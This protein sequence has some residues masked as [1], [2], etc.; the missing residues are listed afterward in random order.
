MGKTNKRLSF[1]VVMMTAILWFAVAPQTVKADVN[2]KE[3]DID[4]TIRDD[5]S[6]IITQEW[7]AYTDEGTEYY[8]Y[9]KDSGYLEFYN[10][11][12][13]DS[14]K[15]YENI[16]EWDVDAEFDEKAYKCGINEVGDGVE[17]CWG[18]SEYGKNHYTITYELKNLV[19]AYNDYDGCLYRFVNAGMDFFPTNVNLTLHF[20][21]K[22]S[23]TDKNARIWGF[24]Y[25]G[26][27]VF[28]NGQIVAKTK[29]ALE[30]E[31]NITLMIC[32]NKGLVKPS[33]AVDESFED[34]I[35]HALEDSD[36]LDEELGEE[37][38]LWI[39]F[40]LLAFILGIVGIVIIFVAIDSHQIKKLKE[41]APYYYALPNRGNINATYLLGKSVKA[42]EEG[43]L[44]GARIT[45]LMLSDAVS[46]EA[47]DTEEYEGMRTLHL[48]KY[49]VRSDPFDME[50]FKLLQKAAEGEDTLKPKKLKKYC[51]KH[52]SKL[53]KYLKKCEEDGEEYLQ[54]NGFIK[55]SFNS[56]H[57]LNESGRAELNQVLGLR[58]YLR[59][60][61][62][63][64]HAE[65]GETC[66]WKELLPYSDLFNLVDEFGNGLKAEYE[67]NDDYYYDSNIL[68]FILFCN[69]S[70]RYS[71]TMHSSMSEGAINAGSSGGGGNA[72]F[73]G[74]AGFSGG[75]GGGVR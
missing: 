11:K 18:I 43:S 47:D 72:S 24:G 49:V 74:G 75:G 56:R 50:L 14:K 40:V 60:Y 13:S 26:D 28:S 73:G 30:D 54:E 62:N 15:T 69:Y 17:L 66:V 42:C 32:M 20:E 57:D 46:I 8:L 45:K 5:G 63:I 2:V 58:K 36:Y 39:I 41:N 48:N 64:N 55:K 34:V 38:D 33:M 53:E 6:A 44:I 27:V 25:D 37:D 59:D 9:Q 10:L 1:I 4:V 67:D 19:R 61:A 23:L 70:H 22:T 68:P 21:D 3:M 65:V 7:D 35:D 12:V 31:S 51:K 71:G 29:T 52:Y 16:G